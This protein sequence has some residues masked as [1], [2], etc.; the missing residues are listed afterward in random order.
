[1]DHANLLKAARTAYEAGQLSE[2]ERLCSQVLGADRQSPEANVL[3]GIAAA[4]T[5][6]TEV[7]VAKLGKALETDPDSFEALSWMSVLLRQSGKLAEALTLAEKAAQIRADDGEILGNLGYC[8]LLTRNAAKATET[9]RK[10]IELRPKEA[11][12]YHNLALSLQTQGMLDEAEGALRT[13]IDLAPDSP[14]N[15][16]TLAQLLVGRA[17][18]DE[19]IQCLQKANSLD[20]GNLRSILE[21]ATRLKEA[22]LDEEA[23]AQIQTAIAIDPK[24]ARAQ[25]VIASI[26]QEMGRFEEAVEQLELSIAR[27]PSF[28]GSYYTWAQCKR[29][30]EKDERIVRQMRELLRSDLRQ[31]ERI[32]LE[33][34]LAKSLDDLGRYEEAIRHFDRHNRGCLEFH[35]PAHNF[36]QSA[37]A[38]EVDRIIAAFSAEAMASPNIPASTSEVPIFI[39]GMIRSGTSLVE[40]IVSCHPDVWAGGELGFWQERGPSLLDD[41]DRLPSLVSDYLSLLAR[42]G[43]GTPRVTDKMPPNYRWIG[44]IHLGLPKAKIIHCRR[45]PVDTCLSIYTTRFGDP[46]PYVLSRENIVFAYRQYERLMEHWRRVLPE[47]TMLELDYEELVA[48]KDGA[49]RRM[50]DYLGLPWSEACLHHEQSQRAV[51]TASIWQARQPLYSTSIARWKNYEPWLGEFAELIR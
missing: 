11:A 25:M 46:P 44:A 45:N 4:R 33:Y 36:D 49:T 10:A 14:V 41:L 50:I 20:P 3:L 26:L 16:S 35:S 8:Y 47:G 29:V 19:A 24:S 30:T 2:V 18:L 7:A 40:Q 9:L 31:S 21:L 51:R 34:G 27:F 43:K 37:F 28:V 17:R 48:D 1:M 13:A 5:G 6:R 42:T 15:Y 32:F 22:G 39:L 38:A 12:L 23:Y